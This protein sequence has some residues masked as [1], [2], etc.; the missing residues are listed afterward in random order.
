[1]DYKLIKN[2]FIDDADYCNVVYQSIKSGIFLEIIESIF[3]HS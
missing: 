1:M 3:I 2:I